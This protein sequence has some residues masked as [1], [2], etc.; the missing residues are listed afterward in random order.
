MNAIA[1]PVPTPPGIGARERS[2]AADPAVREG[3]LEIPGDTVLYHGG[4][5]SGARLAWRMVGPASAPVVCALGGISAGRRVCP[6]EEPRSYAD[7]AES[8]HR[9]RELA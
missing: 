4:R 9:E 3:V 1:E 8:R 7:G 5:L 2:P 6:G